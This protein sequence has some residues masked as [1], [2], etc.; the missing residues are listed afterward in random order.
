MNN[1]TND[2]DYINKITLQYLMNNASYDK[3]KNKKAD[4]KININ[5]LNFYKKRILNTTKEFIKIEID[6]SY[7]S[8]YREQKYNTLRNILLDYMYNLISHFKHEDIKDIIQEHIGHESNN[9]DKLLNNAEI[10]DISD[11]LYEN[12]DQCLVKKKIV[13]YDWEKLGKVNVPNN[14]ANIIIPQITEYNLQTQELKMKGV[15]KKK[16]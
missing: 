12:A 13:K 11:N 16:S 6:L 4:N 8:I 10:N 7:N 1:S 2:E 5:D 14:N 3:L 15:K 9:I